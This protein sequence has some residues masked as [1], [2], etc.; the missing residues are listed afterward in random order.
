MISGINALF[1]FNFAFKFCDQGYYYPL[2]SP[3]LKPIGGL[4]HTASGVKG[5][6]VQ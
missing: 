2:V 5:S 4:L 3:V 1:V 6:T